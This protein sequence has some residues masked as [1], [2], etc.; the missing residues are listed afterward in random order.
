MNN[1]ELTA[2]QLAIHYQK[3]REEFAEELKEHF[4]SVKHIYVNECFPIEAVILFIDNLDKLR[5][6]KQNTKRSK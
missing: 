2:K 5:K 3:G 6:P 4:K 1:D